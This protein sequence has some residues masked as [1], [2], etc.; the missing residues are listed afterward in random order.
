MRIAM[1]Y[2]SFARPHLTGGR[3]LPTQTTGGAICLPARHY[4]LTEL[5]RSVFQFHSYRVARRLADSAENVQARLA[6]VDGAVFAV[7]AYPLAIVQDPR[8]HGV[9]RHA[10]ADAAHVTVRF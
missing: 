10:D 8:F 3:Q 2:D 9:L 6:P 4:A 5:A 1:N 7:G